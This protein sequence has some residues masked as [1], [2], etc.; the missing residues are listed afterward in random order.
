MGQLHSFFRIMEAATKHFLLQMSAR[1][2]LI[3]SLIEM[4]YAAYVVWCEM[5][6]DNANE[7]LSPTTI[8]NRY[9]TL[10]NANE[11]DREG[12][13]QPSTQEPERFFE[14]EEIVDVYG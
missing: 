5:A 9:I 3:M 2:F 6:E 10:R 13:E 11:T 7:D 14:N 8:Q 12:T 4:G 1:T